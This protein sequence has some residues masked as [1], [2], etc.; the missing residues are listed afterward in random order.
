MAS[1]L[2]FANEAKYNIKAVSQKT[3]IQSVT[4]RAWERRYQLLSPKRSENGYRLYSERDI[5]ILGWVKKQVDDGFSISSV[6]AEFRQAINSKNWPEAVINEKGP[7]PSRVSVSESAGTLADQFT[8]ALCRIDERMASDIFSEALGSFNLQQLCETIL[9]P[10]LVEIGSRWERGEVNVSIEHFASYLIE[11]KLQS[12]YHSLPLH[13]SAP[14]VMVG[15][16]PDELH[17]IGSLIFAIL[18]RD[19]GY[20]VEFL[21]PDIPLEDLAL[22][23][24]NEKPRL[25]ILSATLKNSALKLI[26]FGSLMEEITPRPIFGF[27]GA[28]FNSDPGLISQVPGVY[29]GRTLTDSLAKVKTLVPVRALPKLR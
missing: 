29:L 28:V 6:V 22:Y 16:G 2:D 11:G 17:E 7:L 20:R 1:I 13:S 24:K 4:I 18:L 27:G 3:E 8:R 25:I 23:A 5:A 21:G 15:C 19:S 12:I 14:K 9:I 26:Y 10:T